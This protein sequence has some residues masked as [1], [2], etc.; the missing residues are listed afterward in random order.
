MA[1]LRLSSPDGHQGGAENGDRR[2]LDAPVHLGSMAGEE[3][4]GEMPSIWLAQKE[5]A[6]VWIF[7]QS[8]SRGGE[9]G[10]GAMAWRS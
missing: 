10:E 3:G 8:G 7:G 5:V 1:E 2:R 9:R 6:S 4:P